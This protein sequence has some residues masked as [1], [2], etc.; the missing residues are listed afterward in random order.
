MNDTRFDVMSKIFVGSTSRRGALKLLGAGVAGGTALGLGLGLDVTAAKGNGKHKGKHKHAGALT[1]AVSGTVENGGSFDGTYTITK[2]VK[3]TS[4][5][6]A[7]ANQLAALATLNGT[8]TDAN[9][10]TQQVTN[11][12]V[13]IPINLAGTSGT[14]QILHLD[15]GPLD[16]TLLGLQVHLNEVVLDITAQSGSGNLVGNLLCAIAHLLDNNGPLGGLAKLLNK[17][18]QALGTITL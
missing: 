15:L 11:Q 6:A 10:A 7:P 3:Q 14:C 13:T 9:G 16:L 12:A 18:L 4:Q 1:T 17:L 8:L 2:V 5:A